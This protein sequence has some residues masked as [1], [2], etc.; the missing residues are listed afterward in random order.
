MASYRRERLEELIKRIVADTLLTEVKD[1]RIGFVTV[2]RVKLSRD[3]SVADVFVSVLGG[4][5]DKKMTI[6]GLESAKLYIQRIIG[7]E[8]RLR[9]TPHLKFH[10]DTSIEEGVAMVNKIEN[11]SKGKPEREDPDD[12]GDPADGE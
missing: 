3:Y 7:K 4:D 1:P 10:L 8:I 5:K 12:N 2:I 9:I 6:H 11:L